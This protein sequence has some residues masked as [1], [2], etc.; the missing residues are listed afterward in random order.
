MS[1]NSKIKKNH[2]HSSEKMF[3]LLV[4]SVRDYSIFMLDTNGCVST[5]NSGAERITGY[6]SDEIVGKHCSIFYPAVALEKNHPQ[7]EF[8]AA[9]HSGQ[10]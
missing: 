1:E 2:L 6:T 5:W 7:F 9:Q 4:D 3:R 10:L 8:E